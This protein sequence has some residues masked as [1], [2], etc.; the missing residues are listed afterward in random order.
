VRVYPSRDHHD[1]LYRLSPPSYVAVAHVPRP[2]LDPN[3]STTYPLSLRTYLP[4]LSPPTAA[5][6]PS[7]SRPAAIVYCS[8]SDGCRAC[9]N[10]AGSWCD[11]VVHSYDIHPVSHV[12]RACGLPRHGCRMADILAR[13]LTG[14][15]AGSQ[16][17]RAAAAGGPV[18]P[19]LRTKR[20]P[21][22]QVRTKRIIVNCWGVSWASGGWEGAPVCL[23]GATR[24]S[25]A[26]SIS[27]VIHAKRGEGGESCS[28]SRTVPR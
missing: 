25:S 3:A 27:T 13:R 20:P 21:P 2:F 17:A 14:I 18:V 4:M 10:G 22:S 15:R 1:T 11:V 9:G 8:G 16:A 26:P 12:S 5:S 7:V 19:K 23:L 24:T 6:R 28:C